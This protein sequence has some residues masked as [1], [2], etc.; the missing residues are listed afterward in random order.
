MNHFLIHIIWYFQ[1][2]IAQRATEIPCAAVIEFF[3]MVDLLTHAV[4]NLILVISL[5][6]DNGWKRAEKEMW[7]A[8]L[9]NI[10][11]KNF[12]KIR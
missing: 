6:A 9:L 7:N 11:N 10:P 3:G 1:F 12:Y 2:K 8:L 5:K 4:L